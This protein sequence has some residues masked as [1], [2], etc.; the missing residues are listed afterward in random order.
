[1]FS[2]TLAMNSIEGRA[3]PTGVA[4]WVPTPAAEGPSKTILSLNTSGGTFPESTSWKE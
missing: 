4:Y 3:L 2:T 1:M